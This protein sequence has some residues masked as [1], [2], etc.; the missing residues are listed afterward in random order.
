MLKHACMPVFDMSTDIRSIYE[1]KEKLKKRLLDFIVTKICC[2]LS[3]HR[4]NTICLRGKEH[5][6]GE[7]EL[8][9]CDCCKLGA[10]AASKRESCDAIKFKNDLCMHAYRK[11]CKDK[12][13]EMPIRKFFSSDENNFCLDIFNQK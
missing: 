7:A 4:K 11:C 12:E 9:C 2:I 1:L 8:Q 10:K 6:G 3:S 13:R 5:F